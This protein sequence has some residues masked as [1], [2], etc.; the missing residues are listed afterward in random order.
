MLAALQGSPM[1]NPKFLKDKAWGKCLICKQV[2]HGA[3][4]C[5]NCDK[6]PKR[7]C[8]KCH[9]LGHW[10]ALCPGDPRASRSSAKPSLTIVQQDWGGP[11]QPALLSQ[12][13]VT[14]L[15][16]RV[17]LDVQVGQ[18]FLVW[19]RGCLLCPDL[20]IHSLLPNLYHFWCYRE[21][22]YK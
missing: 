9:Q 20:L 14:G 17:H 3:K 13:I 8:Y 1:A 16:P 2:E 11:L 18:R 5:P 10:A 7:A 22:N 19:H 21:N 4:E 12:I 15:E 6:S